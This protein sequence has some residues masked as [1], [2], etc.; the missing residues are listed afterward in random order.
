MRR[1]VLS[2]FL[3]VL[4]TAC[5]MGAAEVPPALPPEPEETASPQPAPEPEETLFPQPAPELEDH[6]L[7]T[8]EAPL[9][10][11]RTLTLEAVGRTLSE[12][13]CGVREVRVYDGDT[14]LQTIPASEG[15][16]Q[17]HAWS[18]EMAEYTEC[19]SEEE[20]MEVL[21]LNFDGSTDFGLFGW[22]CNNNIPFHYWTWDDAAGKYRYACT[23]QGAETH[24][25]FGEITAG[26]KSGWGQWYTDCYCPDENGEL[27]LV[28]REIELWD[29][30]GDSDRSS[31][32]IWE[33]QEGVRIRPRPFQG[34]ESGLTLVRR[35][36]PGLEV[37]NGRVI[38]RFTEIWELRDGELQLTGVEEY[39]EE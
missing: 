3:I 21:D 11:G 13:F 28:R 20:T 29:Q 27:F 14:L 22:V 26:Y 39:P 30:S 5:G 34:E 17:D 10:D 6:V 2:L 23:L 25:E 1:L 7:L 35:E 9:A 15:I 4:C 12:Y 31:V 19:W 32:E 16:L 33:P 8:L 18:G 37:R 24:P 38:S 36:V